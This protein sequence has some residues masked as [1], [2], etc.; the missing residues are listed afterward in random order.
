MLHNSTAVC[1][2]CHYL[3]Y[4]ILKNSAVPS[5]ANLK[6]GSDGSDGSD[7]PITIG[8]SLVTTSKIKIVT[9]SDKWRRSTLP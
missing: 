4:L 8:I 2:H 6:E 3:H 7:N 9:G 1:H 5:I